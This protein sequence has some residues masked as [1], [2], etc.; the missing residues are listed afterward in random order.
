[1]REHFN[2]RGKE[3]FSHHLTIS[4]K[5]PIQGITA[6]SLKE[7]TTRLWKMTQCSRVWGFTH[8]FGTT[9]LSST[10]ETNIMTRRVST[11]KYCTYTFWLLYLY[12]YYFFL[13]TFLT[14]L[15]FNTFSRQ[16]QIDVSIQR[17]TDVGFWLEIKQSGW[18][19]KP[20]SVVFF[21]FLTTI[22][23]ITIWL[24]SSNANF[25]IV[26]EHTSL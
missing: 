10:F 15:H 13:E 18:R 5:F 16:C 19:Q 20:T 25:V 14:S 4:S 6:K 12:L 9:P 26:L 24:W 8:A 17:R 7:F 2:R 1:M 21:F 11:F 23:Y 3:G 22:Q